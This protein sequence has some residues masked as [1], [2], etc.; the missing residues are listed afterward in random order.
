MKLKLDENLGQRGAELLRQAGHDIA[1]VSAQGLQSASDSVLIEVCRVE[2]RCLI[3]LDLDFSNPISFTPANYA[4][5]VVLRLPP[6]PLPED[7]VSTLQTLIAALEQESVVGKLW[8]IQRG[9]L[10]V[11]QPESNI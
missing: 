7:L 6:R 1:T 3:T 2:E 8:T 10:R 9:R 11:Y 5:I 4:G